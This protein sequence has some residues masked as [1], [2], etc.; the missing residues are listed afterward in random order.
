MRASDLLTDLVSIPVGFSGS[1]ALT[2][3]LCRR[4]ATGEAYPGKADYCKPLKEMAAGLFGRLFAGK[5]YIAKWLTQFF[6][7]PMSTSSPRYAET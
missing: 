3:Q 5:G 6:V 4:V 1:A 2:H 7:K